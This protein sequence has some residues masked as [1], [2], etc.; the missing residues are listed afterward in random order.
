VDDWTPFVSRAGFET[1]EI[2]YTT[3]SLSN[4]VI[5]NLLSIWSATLAPH[6]DSAPIADHHDL[7]TTIDAIELGHVPWRSYTARYN[8]LRPENGPAPE[9]M[10]TDYEVWYRDPREV[11]HNIFA[12]PDLVD[13]FDYVPYREFENGKRQ[14]S[15]LMSGDWAW[16]QCV[17]IPPRSR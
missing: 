8:G 17:C 10:T 12:N 2:L 3:A 16:N 5:D 6:D 14:Y 15:D 7:H 4:N 1:A 11:I 9:W 13:G